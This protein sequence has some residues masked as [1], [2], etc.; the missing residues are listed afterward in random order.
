MKLAYLTT[1]VTVL[2]GALLLLLL[3]ARAER[4]AAQAAHGAAVTRA[5]SAEGANA[6]WVTT[7][8]LLRAELGLCQAEFAR[9]RSEGDAA[10]RAAQAQAAEASRRR[11]E[12]LARVHAAPD[13][14]K[15]ALAAL[16]TAC[17]VGAY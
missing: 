12:A 8:D 4:D 2:A 14:C 9:V 13:G 5:E 11:G 16:D 3:G 17:P 1:A 10:V 7:V 6:G 15:A